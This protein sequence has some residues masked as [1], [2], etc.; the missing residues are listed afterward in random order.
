MKSIIKFLK[1]S[2]LSILGFSVVILIM[3]VGLIVIIGLAKISEKVMP[4]LMATSEWCLAIFV[5]LI[6]PLSL[7]KP[8]RSILLIIS[9]IFSFVF[10][11]STWSLALISLWFYWGFLSI[12][13][14]LFLHAFVPA[15]MVVLLFKGRFS[16]IL[17]LLIGLILTYGMRFYSLWL[18]RL[19]YKNQESK[20]DIIDINSSSINE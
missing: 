9:Y 13:L 4:Y 8:L 3:L 14:I 18:G 10:G 19:Q 20:I 17:T 6:L 11:I 2:S 1:N 12:F 16:V 15:T 5:L 7:I